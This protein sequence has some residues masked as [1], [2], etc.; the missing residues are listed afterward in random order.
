MK[1]KYVVKNLFVHTNRKNAIDKMRGQYVNC[2]VF[3]N[4]H[5]GRCAGNRDIFNEILSDAVTEASLWLE[6]N[7][8]YTTC[9]VANLN[10]HMTLWN[11]VYLLKD[12]CKINRRKIYIRLLDEEKYS[13]QLEDS[14]IIWSELWKGVE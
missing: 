9:Y 13:T 11:R 10:N 7:S 2:V 6:K 12:D 4:E 8:V 5:T 3:K 14:K 1:E